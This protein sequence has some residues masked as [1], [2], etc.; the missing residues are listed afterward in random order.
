MAKTETILFNQKERLSY[1]D[2]KYF[3]NNQIFEKCLNPPPIGV[4]TYFFTLYPNALQHAGT[5]NMS[6]IE[7]L[8]IKMA[9]NQV[10]STSNIGLFRAYAETYN[11]L[12][13]SN[14]LCAV[15]FDN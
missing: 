1:R 2:S 6:K 3:R 10:L 8:E 4:N 12:R 9:I 14:G 11:I 7:T 5:S 15:L 13:I